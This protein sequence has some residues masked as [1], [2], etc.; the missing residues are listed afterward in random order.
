VRDAFRVSGWTER[1]RRRWRERIAGRTLLLV[2]DVTTTGA[3]L[4]EGARVLLEAGAAE[5][6]A[7]TL[8]RVERAQ[9]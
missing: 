9:R 1:G 8:A 2:D 3:T 7:V 4:E 5:V 6:R